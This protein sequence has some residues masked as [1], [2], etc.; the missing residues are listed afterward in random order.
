VRAGEPAQQQFRDLEKNTEGLQPLGPGIGFGKTSSRAEGEV[1][2]D[3]GMG[4]EPSCPNQFHVKES[5]ANQPGFVVFWPLIRVPVPCFKVGLLS[6]LLLV[7]SDVY[8]SVAID[9]RIPRV[10]Q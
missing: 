8:L 4:D 10:V 5:R 1:K 7:G 9:P 3:P 6:R 2:Q